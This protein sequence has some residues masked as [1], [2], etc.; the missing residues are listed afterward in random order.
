MVSDPL[1]IINLALT[2]MFP[3]KKSPRDVP[4]TPEGFAE[5]GIR[6]ISVGVS[7]IHLD[8]RDTQ[9]IPVFEQSYLH[10][11]GCNINQM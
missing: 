6:F 9:G 5:N 10:R 3:Y 2:G 8:A 7:M 11:C 1:G 4:I